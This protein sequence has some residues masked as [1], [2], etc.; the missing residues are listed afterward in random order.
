MKRL[1]A[2]AVLVVAGFFAGGPGPG[3]KTQK[4]PLGGS[5]VGGRVP[6]GRGGP[7]GGPPPAGANPQPSLYVFTPTHYSFMA[8][9]GTKQRPRYPSNDKA[10]ETEKVASFDGFYANAGSYT[11]DGSM[12]TTKSM[13][14]KSEFAMAGN[15]NR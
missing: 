9:L 14:A 1:V 2:A 4:P 13:V 7:R 6:S 8:I 10:T 15:I 12:V 11:V 5:G 3:P